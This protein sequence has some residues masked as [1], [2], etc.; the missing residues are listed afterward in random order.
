M[1]YQL[2]P[3]VAEQCITHK[4]NLL[5][6]SY[7]SPQLQVSIGEGGGEGGRRREGGGGGREEGGREEEEGV[8]FL[9]CKRASTTL[10]IGE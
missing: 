1:P 6:S 8:H 7:V 2:H 9:G 10:Q 4:V 5:T 3:L